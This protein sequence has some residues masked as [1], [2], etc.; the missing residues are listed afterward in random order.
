MWAIFGVPIQKIYIFYIADFPT[1]F[2]K[3]SRNLA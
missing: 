2:L 3:E 1:K